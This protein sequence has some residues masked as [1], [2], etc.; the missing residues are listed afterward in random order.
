MYRAASPARPL[1]FPLFEERLDPFA[2]IGALT[3]AGIFADGRLN[4]RI[5]F[6]ARVL[7]KQALGVGKGERTVLRQLR[8]EF[9]GPAEQLLRRHDFVDQAHLQGLRRVE[10]AARKQEVASDFLG[11]LAQEK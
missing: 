1:W 2:K 9:A 11:D 6:R 8:G 7:G 10:D 3:D 5:K 4:L